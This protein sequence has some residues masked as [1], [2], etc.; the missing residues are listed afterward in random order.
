M[1]D[2]GRFAVSLLSGHLGG[3]N[4]LAD[5]CASASGATAVITTATDAHGLPSFD[6]LAKDQGW[7]IDDLS[8][9]KIL[10]SLLLEDKEIAVVDPTGQQERLSPDGKPPLLSR[11]SVR[12][13]AS[14]GYLI[15]TR[16]LPARGASS[17]SPGAP[18]RNLVLSIGCNSGTGAEGDQTGCPDQSDGACPFHQS[19]CCCLPAPLPSR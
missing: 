3:A 7:V 17:R 18:A 16:E 15:P 2:A 13:L 4:R 19:V 8:R 12:L 6:L 10:N 14:H 11:L 5:L 9:V 1:D